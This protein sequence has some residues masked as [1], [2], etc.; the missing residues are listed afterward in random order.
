M[1]ELRSVPSE[2]KLEQDPQSEAAIALAAKGASAVPFLIAAL[3]DK[4]SQVRLLAAWALGEIGDERSAGA[5]ALR[6]G[7]GDGFVRA[8]AM[9]ALVQTGPSAVNA[10]LEALTAEDAYP[11]QLAACALGAIGDRRATGGL[12]ALVEDGEP[13]VRRAVAEALGRIGGLEA[14]GPLDRLLGG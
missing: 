11:R 1:R 2:V 9:T 7:D 10:L 6:L 13:G 3:D 14:T 8:A 12:S 4:E 5:L